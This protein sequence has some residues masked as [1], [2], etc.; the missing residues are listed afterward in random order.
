MSNFY[1]LIQSGAPT[2]LDLSRDNV[3]QKL[4]RARRDLRSFAQERCGLINPA[5]PCRCT[6]KTT[7]FIEA[8]YVNPQNLLFVRERVRA[9]RDVAP[10]VYEHLESAQ[11]EYAEMHRVHPFHVPPTL[12]PDCNSCSG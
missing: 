7:A 2:L 1:V 6:R 12:L 9:V 4:A 3:R 8:G 5:N 11:R 10:A